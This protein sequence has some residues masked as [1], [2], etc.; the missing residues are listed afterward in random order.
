MCIISN[1]ISVKTCT[2]GMWNNPNKASFADVTATK[3]TGFSWDSKALFGLLSLPWWHTQ[4]QLN[5]HHDFFPQGVVLGIYF[6]QHLRKAGTSLGSQVGSHT[7]AGNSQ[8][9][10]KC[11]RKWEGILNKSLKKYSRLFINLGVSKSVQNSVCD[12]HRLI[13]KKIRWVV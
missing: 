7:E 5:Q 1:E 11:C 3:K 8:H 4:L 12:S 13:K 9:T 2:D 6:Q 10:E